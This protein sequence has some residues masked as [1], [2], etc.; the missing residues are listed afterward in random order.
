MIGV[1]SLDPCWIFFCPWRSVCSSGMF[2]CKKRSN[3]KKDDIWLVIFLVSQY[4]IR[5]F[6]HSSTQAYFL[7]F[8]CTLHWI[9]QKAACL[10]RCLQP[11]AETLLSSC[12]KW[13]FIR[14]SKHLEGAKNEVNTWLG[15]CN[16]PGRGISTLCDITWDWFSELQGYDFL[17]LDYYH[18]E[19]LITNQV[20][21]AHH[22]PASSILHK[23]V[24]G[25][26]S[27]HGAHTQLCGGWFAAHV[28][29]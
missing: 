19:T 10:A 4:I 20:N 26:E 27:K 13:C 16:Q 7:T 15:C 3:E 24:L 9:L 2:Y 25:S 1:P 12:K 17:L 6:I 5:Y 8:H 29:Q 23:C 21:L 11:L 18:L 22:G 14:L 28:T